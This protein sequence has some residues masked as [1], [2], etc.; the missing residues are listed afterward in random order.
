MEINWDLDLLKNFRRS[1][2]TDDDS[3]ESMV[4]SWDLSSN[5]ITK[6]GIINYNPVSSFQ[7]QNTTEINNLNKNLELNNSKTSFN[8]IDMTDKCK[9][10]EEQYKNTSNNSSKLKWNRN[11]SSSRYNNLNNE[12]G[13]K[14]LNNLEN[15]SK[16]KSKLSSNPTFK[17]YYNMKYSQLPKPTKYSDDMREKWVSDSLIKETDHEDTVII[18]ENTS[19]NEDFE[20]IYNDLKQLNLNSDRAITEDE[21]KQF[22]ARVTLDTKDLN[23]HQITKLI[24]NYKFTLME[25]Q[26]IEG[27]D[28]VVYLNE[29]SFEPK[30]IKHKQSPVQPN[31]TNN[32]KIKTIG[33]QQ[34]NNEQETKIP[35]EKEKL[36]SKSNKKKLT[37][38]KS[39]C[40]TYK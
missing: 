15:K 1:N 37:R 38:V 4:M 31:S 23:E 16:I 32:Y 27:S 36:K 10:G 13:L 25:E 11:S 6:D 5:Y 30:S 26:D 9:Q 14:Q 8:V 17:G 18:K 2:L 21:P 35:I 34:E 28:S 29:K 33:N 39:P 24:P 7:Q 12:C 3:V 19:E 20:D 22:S 40:L